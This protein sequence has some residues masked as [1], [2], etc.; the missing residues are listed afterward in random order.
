M[1]PGTKSHP[2]NVGDRNVDPYPSSR[3][4]TLDQETKI[5]LSIPKTLES[6]KPKSADMPGKPRCL[7][8][9]HRRGIKGGLNFEP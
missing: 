5:E 2:A 6:G 4:C 8:K 1:E 3:S 7:G 9:V